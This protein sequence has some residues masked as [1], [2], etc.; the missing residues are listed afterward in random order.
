VEEVE[1]DDDDEE[2][3]LP[4]FRRERRSKAR[5]DTSSLV[6]PARMV[7]IQ[8]LSM[9]VVDGILEEAIREELMLELPSIDVIDVHIDRSDESPSASLLTR[10][11]VSL[12]VL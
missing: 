5:S 10:L 7:D 6:A 9:S 2:E 4:L 3:V 12:L 8:G 1:E 11:E